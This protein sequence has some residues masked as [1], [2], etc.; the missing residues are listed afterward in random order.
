M[1]TLARALAAALL[2]LPLAFAAPAHAELSL[3]VVSSSAAEITGND[4]G[5]VGPG[6]RI[7]IDVTLS[8]AAALEGATGTLSTATPGVTLNANTADFTDAPA[9]G[10]TSNTMPFDVGLAGNM[11]CGENLAFALDLEAGGEAGEVTFKIPT[12][13]RGPLAYTAG[14]A[15]A[16]ADDATTNVPVDL[17]TGGRVKALEVQVRSLSHPRLADLRL[18]LVAPDGASILLAEAGT[19][20]GTTMTNT[21]FAAGEPPITGAAAPYTGRYAP[22]DDL[23]DLEGRVLNGSWQLRVEDTV[24]GESGTLATWGL[25]AARAFCFGIP[26]AAF[27]MNPVSV[28]PGGTVQF[29]GNLSS[30]A[31]GPI[32]AYAWDLDGD[33]AFDD[34]TTR[35]VQRTYPDKGRYSVRLRVT[36]GDGLT[37][38]HVRDLAVTLPPTAALSATPTTPLSGDTFRLDAAGSNDPDGTIARYQWDVNGDGVFERDTQGTSFLDTAIATPGNATVRVL[39]TDDDGAQDEHAIV[40]NVQNRPPVADI[41]APA[42][43]LKDRPTTLTAAGSSDPDGT[44]DSY[45]WDLDGNGTYETVRGNQPTVTHTFSAAGDRTVGLRVKDTLNAVATTTAVIAVTHAPVATVTATPAPVSLRRDVTFDASGSSDPDGGGALT[46]AW[47]LDADA[48]GVFESAGG[49]TRT[50]SWPTAGL[51]TV[52]VRVTDQSGAETVGSA[53][54][55][56]RNVLPLATLTA[57]PT[58]PRAGQAVQLSAAG[59]GD[60]DGTIVRF[61]W[62]RD[63]DGTYELDTG[64]TR[65]ASATFAN[66]G[67]V[68]VGVRVT[69]DDGG[70]GTKTLT[71]GVLPAVTA[72]VKPPGGGTV[73]TPPPGDTPPA[74]AP[75]QPAGEPVDDPPPPGARPLAAWIGGP[76]AQ[77]TRTVRARGLL[78][79][80][81]ADADAACAVTVTL[82]ARDAKRLRLGRKA[83]TVARG[84]L[85][86]KAGTTARKRL[87]LSARARRALRGRGGVQLRLRAV[88]RTADGREVALTRIVRLRG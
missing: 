7:R 15:Q 10:Q 24:A 26:R 34:G 28:T 17:T 60:A 74:D 9:G 86:V 82:S 6:D 21:I 23:A 77:R 70:T 59:A 22:A 62:D 48:A 51:R 80:C 13:T 20:S 44:V 37:D 35:Q 40:V 57:T 81:R 47:D 45:E 68:T 41:G 36:D 31:E 61:Q 63:G 43:V 87:A 2:C 12:G 71:I 3:D 76:A 29:D 1:P 53:T 54:V 8:S 11:A 25:D 52:R 66:A 32:V 73:V 14:P 16:L 50:L 75:T 49:A 27:S 18:S 88:A 38:V 65:S 69:D 84:S 72:P 4:D 56:V 67:N 55:L 39:V 46:F 79:S 42:V 33:G 64:T 19:L 83:V 58:A 5:V 30:D 78:V 85:A